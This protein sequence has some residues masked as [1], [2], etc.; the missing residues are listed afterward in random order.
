MNSAGS[1]IRTYDRSLLLSGPKRNDVLDLREVNQYGRDSFGD[2]DY[3]YG[4]TPAEWYARGV[5]MLGR[6]AVECTRDRLA[7]LVA[8]DISAV[9]RTAPAVSGSVVIDPFAGSGNTLYWIRRRV[10]AGSG[11]G[12]ELD[13]AVLAATRRNLAIVGLDIEL[14][15]EDYETGLRALRIAQDQLLIAFVA[16]PWG[17]ALSRESGLDLRRTQPPVAGVVDFFATTFPRHRLLIGIQVHETVDPDTVADVTSKFD[18]S[19]L[20][21]YETDP[22]GRNH[23]LLLGTRGWT[24]GAESLQSP[25]RM[26]E[27]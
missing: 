27:E 14:L 5:R 4:L 24:A 11:I 22:P 1:R 13:A 16:P 18:W 15:H 19:T 9:A 3:V 26:E 10:G 8:S 7:E 23:G 6:T 17:D 2:P 12:F 20:K 21:I 25:E